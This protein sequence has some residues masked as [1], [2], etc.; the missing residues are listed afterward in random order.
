[1][2]NAVTARGG[3]VVRLLAASLAS[4]ALLALGCSSTQTVE[5]ASGCAD[6]C[7]NG[8]SARIDCAENPNITCTENGD[9]CTA[10]QYGCVSGLF[11]SK[12][13]AE[14][15]EG[16]LVRDTSDAGT[17][18]NASE[19]AGA[20][21][22]DARAVGIDSGGLFACGDAACATASQYCKRTSGGAPP[23]VDNETCESMPDGQ[24]VCDQDATND[25]CS[26]AVDAGA[27]YVS[28]QV[29]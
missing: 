4:L 9:P 17:D 5:K 10:N 21:A 2:R 26:C 19:D 18:A 14:L 20:G 28:C 16:C 27:T 12:Q 25:G 8:V 29:P 11:F 7:C 15:P 3:L 22:D 24:S 23:G 6:P 13:P 1:M